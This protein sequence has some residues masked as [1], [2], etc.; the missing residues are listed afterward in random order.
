MCPVPGIGVGAVGDG[1]GPHDVR[2]DRCVLRRADVSYDRESVA[3]GRTEHNP[4]VKR[5]IELV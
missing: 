4:H 3:E 5:R 1:R 2:F